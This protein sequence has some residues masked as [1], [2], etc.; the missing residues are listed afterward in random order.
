[1]ELCGIDLN[2]EVYFIAEIGNN[3]EGNFDLAVEMIRMA[4]NSGVHA[5]KFQTFKTDN[6]ISSKITERYEQLAS[7]EFSNEQWKLLKSEANRLKLVFCS[8][9][10]DLVSATFLNDLVPFFKI[11]S[12]DNSFFPLLRTVAGFAK[13]IILSCGMAELED[14]KITKDY[15]QSIWKDK[16]IKSKIALLHCVSSYPTSD[17]DAN[18]L[19]I[20]YLKRSLGGII[21][22]SDHTLGIDAACTA[23]S[24]GAQ[25]I[26]KHFTID[27]NLSDFHDHKISAT[28]DEFKDLV[29]RSKRIRNLLGTETKSIASSERR[30]ILASRRSIVAVRDLAKGHFLELKDLTWV[31]PTGGLPP[32]KENSLLGRSLLRSIK[33]HDIITE[34]DIK[35]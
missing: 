8:T 14:I 29:E 25:I 6:F 28:P 34:M 30:T 31:R 26:E 21:G 11:S 15:I 23:V 19:S 4:A 13:P 24:L 20:P 27:K 1:L 35:P 3:H 16:G 7:Y 10:F 12:G 18:L 32:G 2:N 5:V 22:Y 17:M 9:P 33:K